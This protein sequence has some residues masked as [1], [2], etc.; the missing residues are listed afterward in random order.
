M[1]VSRKQVLI[2]ERA[3]LVKE[4]A[5]AIDAAAVA[6]RG[7]DPEELE[8]DD[9]INVRI[10]AIEAE[11]AVLDRHAA[12]AATVSNS[13]D[14][15]ATPTPVASPSV[16]NITVSDPAADDPARGF[17]T[18]SE[19]LTSV[20][21]AGLHQRVDSRLLPL[22]VAAGSDEQSGASD[23]YG[24]FLVPVAFSPNMLTITPEDDFLAGMTTS[25]P[26]ASPHVSIPARTDTDHT[27][28]VAGGLTVTRKPETVA[29]T[30]SRMAM[31]AVDLRAGGLFGF[32]YATEEILTDSAVSFVSLIEQSFSQAFAGKLLDERINGLGQSQKE[33][34]GILKSGALVSVAK[35]T[36]QTADTLKAANILKMRARAWNYSRAMWITNHDCY[37]QLVEMHIAGTNGDVFIFQPGRGIDAPDTL[38]GRPIVFSEYASTLGDLGDI[39]LVNWDEYLEG[40]LQPLE[41]AESVH[42][43][44]LEHERTFKFWMRNAGA[45]WWK[46]ALTPKRGASTLSPYVTLAARA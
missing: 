45:P 2:Q 25:I 6:Q 23:P 28:S 38:L 42:V 10:D 16:P 40:V 3:E 19:F 35:E 17:K 7:L 39:M 32:A 36:S 8:R 5:T 41:S 33:F 44:F 27:T 4:A 26:M 22:R 20:I 11:I 31:S 24:S 1:A 43:R 46:A 21:H 9:A 18:P 14:W 29:G 13:P 30:A 15:P 34:L 37:M 12:R